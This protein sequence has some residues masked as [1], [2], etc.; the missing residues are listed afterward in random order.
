MYLERAREITRTSIF[1]I[2]GAES[3]R[4]Q[5]IT[6]K[7]IHFG[8]R[9]QRSLIVKRNL[10]KDSARKIMEISRKVNGHLM[11]S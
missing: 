7:N 8:L 1:H 4:K 5:I 9:G 10:S 11:K 2:S 6:M 3:L